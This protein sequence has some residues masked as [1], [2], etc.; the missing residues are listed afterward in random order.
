[1][2][3]DNDFSGKSPPIRAARFYLVCVSGTM[4]G[5]TWPVDNAP[6]IIGRGVGCHIVLSDPVV[7]RQHC[8]L[9]CSDGQVQ[10][11]DQG[12]RNPALLNGVPVK[13]CTFKIGDELAVGRYIFL[14]IK[15][16]FEGEPDTS[17]HMDSA[18]ISLRA[19]AAISLD[20]SVA[21]TVNQPRVRTVQDLALLHQ[22]TLDLGRSATFSELSEALKRHIQE[23]FEPVEFWC[24]RVFGESELSFLHECSSATPPVEDIQEAIRKRQG[25]L[26]KPKRVELD[27][28]KETVLTMISP[29]ILGETIIGVLALQ[30]NTL[31]GSYHV[32]HLKQLILIAQSLAPFIQTVEGLEQLKRDNERLRIQAGE[33]RTLMGN[34]RG[35]TKIRA[36]LSRIAQ[37]EL[38][39]LIT[40]ETG[41]GK[42]LAASMIHDHSVR[43]GRAFIV[44]NCAALPQDLFESELFGHAKGAFTGASEARTGLFAL[45]HEGTLFLDEIGDLSLQNQARMLRAIE[46]GTFRPVGAEEELQVDVRVVAATNKDLFKAIASHEFREDLYHRINEFSVEMLPLRKHPSDIPLLVQHFFDMARVRAKH[47]VTGIN[48]D[49]M[50]FLSGLKW[51]GNVR[52]LRNYV[53]RLVAT[54]RHGSISLDD[55]PER[56]PGEAVDKAA[57]SLLP[58]AEVEKHHI[59]QCLHFCGGNVSEAA[60]KLGIGRSTLY[61]KISEYSI[62]V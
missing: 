18:T 25:V 48:E 50:D 41:T 60:K 31:H 53:Q 43:C 14:L 6:L 55:L 37:S 1:M 36:D 22:M 54:T 2:V 45:A 33:S 9:E 19:G 47:P 32:H 61:N 3:K 16:V 40:G 5:A 12:S 29:I 21:D 38:N 56:S 24:A 44:V 52:E 58:L 13:K 27:G 17:S 35:M 7:S 34:S 11:E 49:V 57:T 26:L 39:V 28:K 8:I 20:Y 46:H 30:T 51:P 15:G 59:T 23:Q 4:K 42:E 10:L 62:H